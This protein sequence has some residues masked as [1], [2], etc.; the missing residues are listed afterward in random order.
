MA[1]ESLSKVDDSQS[2]SKI[3]EQLGDT[4]WNYNW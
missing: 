1:T 2:A 3:R 4:K